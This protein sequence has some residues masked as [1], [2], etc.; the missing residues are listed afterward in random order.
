[1]KTWAIFEKVRSFLK[2]PGCFPK[3]KAVFEKARPF[4]KTLVWF[5]KRLGCFAKAVMEILGP[6]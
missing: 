1:M 5:L 2:R 3:G 4:L 6:F